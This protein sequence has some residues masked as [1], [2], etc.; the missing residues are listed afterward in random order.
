M[1]T[2]RSARIKTMQM[3]YALETG[4]EL[5]T[6]KARTELRRRIRQSEDLYHVFMLYL[7]EVCQ[8]NLVDVARRSDK[9]IP[10]EAD[11]ALTTRLSD[12][13]VVRALAEHEGFRRT[14]SERGL[15]NHVDKSI[16]KA[17][18]QRLLDTEVFTAFNA[19]ET[20][21][22]DTE[23]RITVYILKKVIGSDETLE[24]RLSEHF[25]QYVDDHFLLI[26]SLSKR[27]KALND[28]NRVDPL[29]IALEQQ[30]ESATFA[31]ELLAACMTHHDD[32]MALIEPRLTNWDV[33]RV[34]RMD[35]VL[36]RMA[37]AEMLHFPFIPVKVT[38][39]EYIDIAKEYSTERSK[40]F[41]NGILDRLLANL[42]AEGRI[43][44]KGR[45]LI[46]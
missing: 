26:H 2:R 3:L 42:R 27:I 5:S 28:V 24:D 1:L 16:V 30:A 12:L 39:N 11:K 15:Y 4:Q 25:M 33:D 34:A 18:Y 6:A 31:E 23:K 44:K 29:F 21:D 41:V 35:V 14:V 19:T 22:A 43:Q 45:G 10:T 20:V 37:L 38:M 7:V 13:R 17:L 36:L 9:F 32:L 40:D 46:E 8:Y